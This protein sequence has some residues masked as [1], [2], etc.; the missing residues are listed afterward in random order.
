LNL[1]STKSGA[2]I[3]ALGLAIRLNQN[4]PAGMTRLLVRQW[5]DYF[6]A[7]QRGTRPL[8]VS[9]RMIRCFGTLRF[10]AELRLIVCQRQVCALAFC[11]YPNLDAIADAINI[12]RELEAVLIDLARRSA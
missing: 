12:E 2:Y 7:C 3:A 10:A 1:P 11:D 4:A 5:L 8:S 9:S 6:H